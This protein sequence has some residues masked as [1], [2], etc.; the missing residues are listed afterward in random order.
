LAALALLFVAA[1]L[2]G[3]V[4]VWTAA[5][6]RVSRGGR[7]VPWQPRRCVPWSGVELLLCAALYLLVLSAAGGV[8]RLLGRE[9][10][11]QADDPAHLV[12][13][14]AINALVS[15]AVTAC[16]VTV[17]RLRG[18]TW[19]DLGL[20][21]G[22]LLADC[23]LG[24][25]AFLFVGPA[26]YALQ[27]VLSLYIEGR[28]PLIDMVHTGG[29]AALWLAAASALLVAP[30]CEE[31]L[32]RVI[33]QGWLEK[34]ELLL[35]GNHLRRADPAA[36]PA[37][38][39]GS[40]APVHA[41]MGAHVDP[42]DAPASPLMYVEADQPHPRP[43]ERP[44]APQHGE[45]TDAGP[46]PG[47]LGLPQGIL[48]ILLSAGVFA[49]MHAGQ[50]PAPIPLFLFALCLGYLYRQTHRLLPS[51]VVHFCLNATSML[52]LVLMVLSGKV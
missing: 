42:R 40:P 28:H 50:G 52:M 48:P 27:L 24:L 51:V 22:S 12:E 45:R 49:L 39:L 5:L 29:S 2:A 33:F 44:D 31:W 32:F 47:L 16:A 17:L 21:R 30:L 4:A 38:R 13:L 7:L 18:A 19:Q 26:V 37:A 8:L 41:D 15:L 34:L 3:S 20:A 1:F 10:G 14:I 11:G 43:A 6:V 36:A 23:R 46:T 9:A 35:V 25:A